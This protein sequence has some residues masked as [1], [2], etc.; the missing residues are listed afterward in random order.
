MHSLGCWEVGLHLPP[1]LGCLCCFQRTLPRRDQIQ[2]FPLPALP[3]IYLQQTC[4]VILL[5]KAGKKVRATHTRC[6][7]L[8]NLGQGQQGAWILPKFRKKTLQLLSKDSKDK[9]PFLLYFGSMGKAHL[10]WGFRNNK[11]TQ[12]TGMHNSLQISPEH[13]H[14]ILTTKCFS[15]RPSALAALAKTP[16]ETYKLHT[17]SA[18]F[19]L[20]SF[21]FLFTMARVII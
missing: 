18:R 20:L 13:L 10:G 7:L 3:I 6:I 19:V 14:L 2:N 9:N 21:P 5:R 1:H 16:A 11:V 4:Q 12:M 15:I 8:Q 17:C